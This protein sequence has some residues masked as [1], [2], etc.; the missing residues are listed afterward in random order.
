MAS[1]QQSCDLNSHFFRD[2]RTGHRKCQIANAIAAK[3]NRFHK[4]MADQTPARILGASINAMTTPTMAAI[5]LTVSSGFTMP[6]MIP[7]AVRTSNIIVNDPKKLIQ[8]CMKLDSLI[9]QYSFL[10]AVALSFPSD[11]AMLGVGQDSGA[12]KLDFGFWATRRKICRP[13]RLDRLLALRGE[14]S[15]VAAFKSAKAEGYALEHEAMLLA[16]MR[17]K[18]AGTLGSYQ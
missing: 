9:L 11:A 12:V 8:P 10:P 18:L 15:E 6:S 1:C 16:E 5:L 4:D 13:E 17:G 2:S 7:K 14:R 3:P